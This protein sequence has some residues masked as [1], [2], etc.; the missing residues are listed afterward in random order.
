MRHYGDVWTKPMDQIAMKHAVQMDE[1]D[2]YMNLFLELGQQDELLQ[3]NG[4]EVKNVRVK[5]TK[6]ILNNLISIVLLTGI[7][8]FILNCSVE[9]H[10]LRQNLLRRIGFSPENSETHMCSESRKLILRK[11]HTVR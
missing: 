4:G 8:C 10:K 2:W 5:A 9:R 6:F 7:K 1:M 11:L 3:M